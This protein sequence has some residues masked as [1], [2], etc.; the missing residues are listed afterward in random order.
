[1]PCGRRGWHLS[2]SSSRVAHTERTAHRRA[3]RGPC[4]GPTHPRGGIDGGK[5]L[6]ARVRSRGL[7]YPL[8]GGLWY[9]T[10]ACTVYHATT[11]ATTHTPQ[12]AKPRALSVQTVHTSSLMSK[13]LTGSLETTVRE[14]ADAGP[15]RSKTRDTI[16][17]ALR[18]LTKIRMSFIYRAKTR[19]IRAPRFINNVVL[20]VPYHAIHSIP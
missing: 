14:S 6:P 5:L 15:R 4:R 13:L 8:R 3:R 16:R 20:S 19:H 12:K 1:M 17:S 9:G 18:E 11:D 7:Y 10:V 2:E